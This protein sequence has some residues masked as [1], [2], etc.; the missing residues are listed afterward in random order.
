MNATKNVICNRQL[1]PINYCSVLLIVYLIS[2][3]PYNFRYLYINR[4]QCWMPDSLRSQPFEPIQSLI[5]P[6]IF[7][8]MVCALLLLLCETYFSFFDVAVVFS[9]I[10]RFSRDPLQ[11]MGARRRTFKQKR[12]NVD[13]FTDIC[14]SYARRS[15]LHVYFIGNKIGA[16]FQYVCRPNLF[17]L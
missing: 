13:R 10:L 7:F 5:N 6:L 4:Y 16:N 8:M 3:V 14:V 1:Q 15:Y 17:N 9:V 12:H 2:M 11:R